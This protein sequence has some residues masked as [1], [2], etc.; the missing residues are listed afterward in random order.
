MKQTGKRRVNIFAQ[1][2]YKLRTRCIP[3]HLATILIP[4]PGFSLCSQDVRQHEAVR[5][6]P[7]RDPGLGAGDARARARLPRALLLVRGVRG[8]LDEGRPLRHA[9]R[10]RAVS[11]ALRDGR[12]AASGP[13]P[14]GPGLPARAALPRPA[15]PLARVP[16]P[17]SPSSSSSSPRAAAPASLDAPPTR[18]PGAA[19][20]LHARGARRVLAPQGALLQRRRRRSPAAQAEGQA[21]EEEAQGS[22][23]HDRES[24]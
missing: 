6:L 21:Q 24:R 11:A 14:A 18:Q 8:A 4:I 19:A 15:L 13:E 20:A 16:P 10:R 3:V 7:G 9:G 12:R 23:D 1:P 5:A 2:K 22:G 17:S